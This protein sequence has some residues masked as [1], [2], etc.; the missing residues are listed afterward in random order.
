[1]S[2]GADLLLRFD[3]GL[4]DVVLGEKDLEVEDG[5]ETAVLLSLFIDARVTEEELPPGEESRRGWFGDLFNDDIEDRIGSKLWLFERSKLTDEAIEQIRET[6]EAALQ[7]MI[8][9]GLADRVTVTTEVLGAWTLGLEIT[10]LRP[11]GK[12]VFKY[13]LNWNS[14]AARER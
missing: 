4:I 3:D 1:M 6:A 8:T 11:S 12:K 5:L 13:N 7:W 14:E 9:D 10:I 2:T